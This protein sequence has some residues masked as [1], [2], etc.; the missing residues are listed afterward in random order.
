MFFSFNSILF[1]LQ[2][3]KYLAYRLFYSSLVQI[4][5]A[6]FTS[7]FILIMIHSKLLIIFLTFTILNHLLLLNQRNLFCVP[8]VHYYFNKLIAYSNLFVNSS[9]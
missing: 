1:C 2:L 9:L 4:L 6:A 3:L 5:F 7:C 8:R